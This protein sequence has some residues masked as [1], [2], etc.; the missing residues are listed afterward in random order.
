MASSSSSTA[1]S[2]N[3]AQ[4]TKLTKTNYLTWFRQIK[5]YLHDAKLWGYVDG[6]I[7][8]PSLTTMTT[9]TDT[10]LAQSIPNP[11]HDMWFTVVQ[12]IVSILTTTLIGNIAQLT[13]GFDTSKAIWGCLERHFSQKSVAS[14]TNLKMQLLDLNKGT[15]S[16]DEYLRHAKSIPDAL[17]SI[18]KHVPNEDLIIATLHGLGPNYIMLRTALTQ[19]PPLPDFTELQAQILSFDAQQSRPAASPT[20]TALF[21]HSQASSARRDHRFFP[22]GGRPNN[23]RFRRGRHSQQQATPQL[24]VASPFP[25]Q[26][27]HALHLGRLLH[28]LGLLVPHQMVFLA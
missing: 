18:N 17:V 4:F 26:Q 20:A 16:V 10:Q 7:S 13:I 14:A 21:N 23:G 9:A 3:T 5:P 8:K 12:Q 6:T 28:L 11:A 2:Q 25:M 24:R 27:Q 15:Q 1:P 22:T 19:N